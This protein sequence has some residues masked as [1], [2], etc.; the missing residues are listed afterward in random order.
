MSGFTFSS[1]QVGVTQELRRLLRETNRTEVVKAAQSAISGAV[2]GELK[3]LRERLIKEGG[4]P[5]TIVSSYVQALD[6]LVAWDMREFDAALSPAWDSALTVIERFFKLSTVIR[7]H[8]RALFDRKAYQD[9][10]GSF[11]TVVQPQ[12]EEGQLPTGLVEFSGVDPGPKGLRPTKSLLTVKS[13]ATLEPGEAALVVAEGGAGKT[14][15]L[16]LIR[17]EVSRD[18]SI[19]RLSVI[20]T[21]A[22]YTPG[23]LDAAIHKQLGVLSGSWRMLPDKVQVL[24]DG[25][26][27]TSPSAVKVLFSELKPLLESKRISCIFTSREDSRGIRTVLPTTPCATL[28]LVPLSP[29]KVRALAQHEIPEESEVVAFA[30]A[31]RDMAARSAG[32]FMWTPFAVRGALKLWKESRQLGDTLGDLLDTIV[33]AR[34]ERDLE[35]SSSDESLDLPRESVLAVA[36][37]LAFEMLVVDGQAACSADEIGATL[38]NAMLLCANVLGVDG[39]NSRQLIGLL[40]KHD[41]IQRTSDESFRWN[42]QLVAGAFAARYLASSWKS[43]IGAL[44]QPLSD[45]AWVFATRTVPE[46]ELSE[47]LD[48]LFHADLMLG[49]RATAELPSCER[50]RSLQYIFKAIQPEQPE[51]LRVTGFFALARVGTE[52]AL[53]FLRSNTQGPR[54]DISFIAARALA[55]SGDRIFLLNLLEKVDRHRRMGWGMS[56]GEI[57]V[58]EE[59]AFADRIAIARERLGSVTPGD[60]VNESVLLITHEASQEDIPLLEAHLNAA[61]DVTA[62]IITLRAIDEVDHDRAKRLFDKALLDEKD[63]SVKVVIM[64]AGADVG[65]FNNADAAFSL[66]MDITEEEMLDKV[67]LKYRYDLIDDV[68][69][70]IPLT[71]TVRSAVESHFAVSKGERKNCLW[72]M[73]TKIDSPVIASAAL[74]AFDDDIECVGMASNFFISH[75][76][77]RNEYR[78]TLQSKIEGYLKYRPHWFTFNS[79]R[80]LALAAEVG[81][82]NNSLDYLKQMIFRLVELLGVYE[83]GKLLELHEDEAHISDDLN[84]GYLRYRL[85]DYAGFL[86]PGA[87]GAAAL[88]EPEVLTKFLHF[89]L[90]NTSPGKEIVSVYGEIDSVLLDDE[91][92][93]VKDAW[94]QLSSLEMVCKFGVTNRRLDML[95]KYL[96]EF[97]CH[98]AGLSTV[99]KALEA[100]WNNSVCKMVV[101]TVSGFDDWP[102]EGQQLF[103]DFIHMVGSKITVA[104]RAHVELHLPLAKTAFARR[105]LRIWRQG[106]LDSRVGLTRSE[107]ES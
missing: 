56:G 89:N 32:S 4:D 65:L 55:Y 97:Y 100:C 59:A 58:W 81:F 24:C 17:S 107:V 95:R 33:T 94:S 64:K 46:D 96:R 45:D 11:S 6:R 26:N 99:R 19:S 22:E 7:E 86:V 3:N 1:V 87:V 30:E 98:P 37:A 39:L 15:L 31:H 9:K 67:D 54:S 18:L 101:E 68:L 53:S 48:E 36:S 10:H 90:A 60:P 88:L 52:R 102:E 51:E 49:A 72:Q 20:I 79:W 103:F 84:T 83:E 75:E 76:A 91:L 104:D 47:Y 21:C 29:G 57:A 106:T 61:K 8:P 80:V 63:S 25:I 105:V 78:L 92:E 70:K 77:I 85:D 38:K 14:T 71:V 74:N 12:L 2:D 40:Q 93:T 28:R 27:E 69:G 23:A 62:W 44:Q 66:L 16:E 35:I 41:L 13:L 82:T 43:H 73:A 50:D 34:A 42:H 5:I